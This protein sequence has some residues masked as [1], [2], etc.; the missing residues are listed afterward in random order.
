MFNS[1]S[2]TSRVSKRSPSRET[3]PTFIDPTKNTDF[4][5][6]LSSFELSEIDRGHTCIS[7]PD[8]DSSVESGQKA[9][10]QIKYMSD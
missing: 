4:S 10:L 7:V 9:T 1:A 3:I 6:L 8:A 2:R 5:V